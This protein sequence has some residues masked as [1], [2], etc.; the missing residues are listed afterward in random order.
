MIQT[1]RALMRNWCGYVARDASMLADV[2]AGD[3]EDASLAYVENVAYQFAQMALANLGR[4]SADENST[5]LLLYYAAMGLMKGAA[6]GLAALDYQKL[7]ID[8]GR[9]N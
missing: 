6:D 2:V 5:Q 8:D 7:K 3:V 9:K 1:D 4:V